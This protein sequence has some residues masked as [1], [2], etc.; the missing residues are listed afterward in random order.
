MDNQIIQLI[1]DAIL[2]CTQSYVDTI[3]EKLPFVKTEIGVISGEGTHKGNKVIIN[4][5][6]A[7]S[8][9]EYDDILSVGNIIFPNDCVVYLFV[10]NGQYNNMFIMGQLDDTPANIVGGT[11]SLGGT[12]I[13]PITFIDDD[14]SGHI[15]NWYFLS[16]I[17]GN[18]A[19]YSDKN[20]NGKLHRIFLQPPS[21]EDSWVISVQSERTSGSG[22]LYSDF[23]VDAKGDV[24]NKGDALIGKDLKVEGSDYSYIDS[25]TTIG[26]TGKS[27]TDKLYVDGNAYVRGNFACYGTKNRVV[28]TENYDKVLFNAYETTS[29]M[30]GDVGIGTLDENCECYIYLDDIFS[31]TINPN[32]VVFLQEYGSG[33]VWIE[34]TNDKYFIVKG[35]NP[36][37]K[38]S[39]E[40]KSK[41]KGYE[42]TRLE[43]KMIN[44]F[45]SDLELYNSKLE[46]QDSEFED[47]KKF[48]TTELEDDSMFELNNNELKEILK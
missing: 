8:G 12:K 3:I 22:I 9:T 16:G 10:P 2:D 47:I 27:P 6:Y 48:E 34:E 26:G 39:W 23:Y 28:D 11:I 19:F 20:V 24:Y 13:N 35:D 33:K 21:S 25:I 14:G 4:K 46:F 36:N 15:G 45:D 1:K 5:T 38:F 30:F 17:V 40:I 18:D 44:N 29:P 7:S 43:N 37:L 42:F 31:E 32:Y 41:Q